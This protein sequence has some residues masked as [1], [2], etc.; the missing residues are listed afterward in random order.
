MKPDSTSDR[1]IDAAEEL[2]AQNGFHHTSLRAITGMAEVNLAAVNYHFGSKDALLQAVFNRHI[3]PLNKVREEKL[4][5]VR[6]Q[7]MANGQPPA[8]RDIM[9][10]FIAPTLRLR[11]GGTSAR[12]FLSL[13]GRTLYEPDQ[14]ARKVFIKGMGPTFRLLFETTC[15]ALPSCQATEVSWRLRFALSAM[16]QVH[17]GP[18][19]TVS[20]IPELNQKQQDPDLEKTLLDFICNGMEGSP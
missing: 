9:V 14:T 6:D 20:L 5:Q 2:F 13:V 16:G 4:R 1:I 11:Q 8:I 18:N 19:L 12:N 3:K 15:Q 10:A 17:A 7:A